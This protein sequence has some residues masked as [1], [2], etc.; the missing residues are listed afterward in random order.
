MQHFPNSPLHRYSQGSI[1]VA[2]FNTR[3][4][5][6]AIAPQFDNDLLLRMKKHLL[7]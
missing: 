7:A 1:V 3:A 4:I 2:F 5:C 6:V